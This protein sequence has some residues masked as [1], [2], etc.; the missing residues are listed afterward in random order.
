MRV[1]M[2]GSAG[3]SETAMLFR[4]RGSMERGFHEVGL[5]KTS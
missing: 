5:I 1:L 4:N 2:A 3:L